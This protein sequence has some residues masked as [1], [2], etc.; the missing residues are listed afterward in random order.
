MDFSAT[1]VMG[2][3]HC[4][5]GKVCAEDYKLLPREENGTQWYCRTCRGQVRNM[6][7]E[8]RKLWSKNKNLVMENKTLKSCL[9]R[10]KKR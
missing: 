1:Y 3:S 4:G 8:N 10:L 2:V 5:C 9:A 6:K 7:D